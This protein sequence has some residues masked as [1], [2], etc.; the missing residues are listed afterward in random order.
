MIS[1]KLQVLGEELYVA[2][3]EEDMLNGGG[4]KSCDV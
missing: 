3:K 4:E 2:G 1:E